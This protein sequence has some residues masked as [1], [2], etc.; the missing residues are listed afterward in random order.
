MVWWVH[1]RQRYADEIENRVR[2]AVEVP[3]N[4]GQMF[5]REAV[6]E[7]LGRS[8]KRIKAYRVSGITAAQQARHSAVSQ[9]RKRLEI[10]GI[11]FI[12]F[13]DIHIQRYPWGIGVDLCVPAEV[14][15]QSDVAML[16]TMSQRLLSRK[17]RLVDL[18]AGYQYGRS[19]WIEEQGA[20]RSNEETGGTTVSTW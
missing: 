9:V 19:D 5:K 16:A 17:V 18:V 12:V 2:T 15:N 20:T 10:E 14:R 6:Y 7:G 1:P 3:L 8:R 4:Q 11:D 13:P